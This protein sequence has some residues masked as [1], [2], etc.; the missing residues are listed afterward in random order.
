MAILARHS[1]DRT[2]TV[3]Q[4]LMAPRA[5]LPK[6]LIGVVQRLPNSYVVVWHLMLGHCRRRGRQGV[7]GAAAQWGGRAAQM[8]VGAA[9]RCR[10]SRPGGLRI[11]PG[12]RGGT[13]GVGGS[14]EGVDHDGER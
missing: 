11:R 2:L 13:R 8:V 3:R 12:L 4:G 5:R 6:K 1:A 9:Q 10:R 7:G 14:A